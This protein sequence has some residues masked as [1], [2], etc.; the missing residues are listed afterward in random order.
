VPELV[1][2]GETGELVPPDD[3]EAL[4]AAIRKLLLDPDRRA[5]LAEAGFQRVR[6]HF[7]AKRGIDDLECRFK[8][9]PL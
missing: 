2:S 9:D 1:I 4:A 5:R 8:R 6:T 3:P 7:A